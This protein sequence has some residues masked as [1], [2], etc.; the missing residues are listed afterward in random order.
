MYSRIGGRGMRHKIGLAIAVSG[1]VLAAQP[2]EAQFPPVASVASPVV[3]ISEHSSGLMQAGHF[4]PSDPACLPPEQRLSLRNDW[5]VFGGADY[6]HIRPHFSEA[7][8]FAEVTQTA[9]SFRAVG[10]DLDVGYDSSFRAFAGVGLG[11]A[12]EQIRF[13]YTDLGG[14]TR[15]EGSAGAP[16]TFLVDPYGN[17]A[18][19]AVV[20]DPHSRLF[21]QVLPGGDQI[22]TQA[23]VDVDIYDLDYVRAFSASPH[24]SLAWSAGLRVADV[25]QFYDSTVSAGGVPLAYGDFAVDYVGV[26][27]R[28]GLRGD[29]SLGGSGLSLFASGHGS[30]LVGEYDVRSGNT[31]FAP[32][33]FQGGQQES[34]TRLIPVLEVEAGAAYQ[35]A[36]N[37]RLSAGWMFQAW[38][39]L[40][41]SGG[42]FGG[43]F[44]G[45][46]DANIMSFDGLM[47][48]AE[49]GF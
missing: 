25:E 5:G 48:R 12:G 40:G 32:A 20:I 19:A 14:D 13:T 30:T 21:G 6:L 33:V 11:E 2:A 31:L 42:T 36:E 38:F 24:G 27:P 26:G 17:I 18:G 47:L 28:I 3:D 34:V 35:V 39:D 7:I 45:A 29:R 44:N 46:D 49:F 23:S 43:F 22:R 4:A 10:R 37:V 41:T 16:G 9:D 1:P 15:V 8:G